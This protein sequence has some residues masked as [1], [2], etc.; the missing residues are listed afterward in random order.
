MN[1]LSIIER[2]CQVFITR[3][4]SIY[5]I[6]CTEQTVLMFLDNNDGINQDA[7]AKYF[8]LDKGA[9]AKTL[10][11]LE[12]KGLVTRTINENNKREKIVSLTKHGKQSMDSMLKV[13]NEWHD[14]MFDGISKEEIMLLNNITE[15][16]AEN[17]T[18][19]L[20]KERF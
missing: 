19:A 20:N 3:K 15:K 10:S 18:K 6:S 11:K 7:I 14:C 13:L 5:A 1:R 4:L 12:S 17:A 9:I 8:F 16:M 2:S